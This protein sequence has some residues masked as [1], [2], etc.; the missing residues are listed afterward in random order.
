MDRLIELARKMEEE[1][2]TPEQLAKVIVGSY[3]QM[4]RQRDE[5]KNVGGDRRPPTREHPP[6]IV[7]KSVASQQR[8][9]ADKRKLNRTDHA[10]PEKRS[11]ITEQQ[12]IP[13][14]ATD[15]LPPSTTEQPTK[16]VVLSFRDE[17]K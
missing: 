9:S 2:A 7:N 1:Q 11:H 14:Q 16:K 6:S 4:D 5:L 10:E 3:R 17:D 13:R 15:K 12:R 8:Q